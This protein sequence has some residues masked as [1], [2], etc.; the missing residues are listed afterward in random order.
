MKYH[1]EMDHLTKFDASMF[2]RDQAM[3]LKTW[4][5]IH[6]NVYN[7]FTTSPKTIQTLKN[8]SWFCDN[9]KIRSFTDYLE[10]TETKT[11]MFAYFYECH[12]D[13]TKKKEEF[14]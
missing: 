10:I 11:T 9:C 2:N 6:T 8:I 13:F 3:D 1:V 7:F 5:K 14:T 4:L 12:R